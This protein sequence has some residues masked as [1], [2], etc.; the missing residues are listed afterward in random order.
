MF[1]CVEALYL[2]LNNNVY[3]KLKRMCYA[4][5]YGRTLFFLSYECVSPGESWVG[6]PLNPGVRPRGR[7]GRH[8]K[9]LS[10]PIF[11]F[12]NWFYSF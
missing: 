3:M 12:L 2:D 10:D 8:T 6:G 1:W 11:L 9:Y 7:W 5:F 4:F